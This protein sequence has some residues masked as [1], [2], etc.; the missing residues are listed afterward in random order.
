MTENIY[1]HRAIMLLEATKNAAVSP[2]SSCQPTFY[3]ANCE[4]IISILTEAKLRGYSGPLDL[5][6]ICC[7]VSKVLMS[8]NWWELV[9][10]IQD[11]TAFA[12]QSNK[13][14]SL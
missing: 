2:M 3:F 13:G 1:V 10:L 4:A 5:T 8:R 14:Q 9:R 7:M 12:K 6:E 11:A